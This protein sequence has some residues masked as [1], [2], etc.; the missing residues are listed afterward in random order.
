MKMYIPR[1]GDQVKLT[2]EWSFTMYHESRN[3]EMLRAAGIECIEYWGGFTPWKFPEG[4]VLKIERIYIRK[5]ARDYDSVTF[6]LVG[7][8]VKGRFWAKLDEV[9]TMEFEPA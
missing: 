6:R 2:A 9:N 3:L 5:G 7:K 4:T 1:L 8:G